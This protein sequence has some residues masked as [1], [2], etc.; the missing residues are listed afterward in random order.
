MKNSNVWAGK[1]FGYWSA[2]RAKICMI[3]CFWCGRENYSVAVATGSC[4]WCQKG[5]LDW[6]A[7]GSRKKKGVKDNEDKDSA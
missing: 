7:V 5:G 6:I 1:G 3:R 2:D 4:A